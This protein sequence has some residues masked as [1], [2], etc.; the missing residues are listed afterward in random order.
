MT[1]WPP[2]AFVMLSRD[3]EYLPLQ[4][5]QGLLNSI[6]STSYTFRGVELAA[7]AAA[8]PSILRDDLDLR[9]AIATVDRAAGTAVVAILWRASAARSG[10]DRDL[11][12]GLLEE[13]DQAMAADLQLSFRDDY[14]APQFVTYLREVRP[15]HWISL[16]SRSALFYN[17]DQVNL[18][19]IEP[20]DFLHLAE[21]WPPSDGETYIESYLAGRG[22]P[23][24]DGSDP[25]LT[26]RILAAEQD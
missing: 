14:F 5:V 13:V 20:A 3:A 26:I 12:A 4:V 23:P 22:L 11:L 24:E 6:P 8:H 2:A 7:V 9:H 16:S 15:A 19:S 17:L 10:Y 18:A 25:L 21:S 1:N